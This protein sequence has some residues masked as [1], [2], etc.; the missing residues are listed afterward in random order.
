MQSATLLE[1]IL[2][3]NDDEQDLQELWNGDGADWNGASL[4]SG[5]A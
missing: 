3:D 2:F 5:E 1:T 4:F